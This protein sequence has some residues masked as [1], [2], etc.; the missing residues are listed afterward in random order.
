MSLNFRIPISIARSWVSRSCAAPACG[1]NSTAFPIPF[2]FV[3]RMD[4]DSMRSLSTNF[5][6]KRGAIAMR[7]INPEALAWFH[8]ADGVRYKA[9]TR[10]D[11]QVRLVELATG[12]SE[13]D[14]CRK[15][16]I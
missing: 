9:V 5:G 15:A 10:H 14:W 13:P 11:R 2:P 3:R 1:W 4:R 6:L 8:P 16:H 7:R 12:F